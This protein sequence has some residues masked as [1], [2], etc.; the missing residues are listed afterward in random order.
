MSEL[1]KQILERKAASFDNLTEKRNV[2]DTAEKIFHGQLNDL[3]STDR[4]KSQVFDPKLATLI[5]E[6][7]YRV[8]AQ[9]GVG[10]VKGISKNDVGDAMLKNLLLEKYVVP[11]ANSQFDFLTKCRMVNLYSNIYG[12]F[13]VLIDW[14]VSQNGYVGPD[15]WLLNIR[16]VFHQVGAVS[17]ED[18]D[19][20]IVRT[21]KPLSYFENLKEKDGFKNL[22]SIITKLK[23]VKDDKMR[24]NANEMGQRELS[25]YPKNT[26]APLGYFEVL[27]QYEKDRWI[28]VV[29]DADMEFRDQKNPHEDNDI[30]IKV[31]YSI[32]LLDDFMGYGDIERGAP[33][34]M[35][36][37]S[38]WNLYLDAVKTSIAPPVLI[39]KTMIADNGSLKMIPGAKWLFKGP[40]GQVAMP[41]NLSP[42]G[43]ATFNTVNQVANASLLN[44]MGTSDTATT[45]ATDPGFGR[46]PQALQMQAARENTRDNADR[47]YQEQFLTS[48][49]KKFCNLMSKKQ[50]S[51]VTIRMFE[52]EIEQLSRNYPDIKNSYDQ[53]SGKL[54]VKKGSG[55]TLYDYEITS[56]STYAADQKQQQANMAQLIELFQKSQ[57]PQGN[58]LIQQ[59]KTDGFN[60]NFGEL[61]KRV[62][63]N[64][65]IQDWDKILTEQTPEEKAQVVLDQSNQQFQQA[66]AGMMGGQGQ[67]MPINPSQVPMQGQP[68]MSMPEQTPDPMP[69]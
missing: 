35:V 30:P 44:M 67:A 38:N 7:S 3:I 12:A 34:Q 39:D 21:W 33:M 24:R 63:T 57:T 50:S 69:F 8:M 48:V 2:W 15:M 66:L 16:D 51:A 13:F 14:N 19:Y 22:T 40:V 41:M 68:Q 20:M 45:Q 32:P 29:V 10:K 27:T 11:N 60:F 56:G 17:P 5:L 62:I 55:S 54:T 53:E 26:N 52:D 65:G 49:M 37:N 1:S 58:A 9:M 47:Y 18:S 6:R 59:L 42:Q 4:S 31:K 43:I 46:T 64:S 25:Q 28:D 23:Q 61:L 36:V